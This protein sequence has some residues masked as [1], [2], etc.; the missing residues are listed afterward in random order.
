MRKLTLGLWTAG[1]L[2]L[3]TSTAHGFGFGLFRSG[4]NSTPSY[5]SSYYPSYYSSSYPYYSSY[6][7]SSYSSYYSSFY[8]S[9][10]YS[11][12]Y[13]YPTYYSS[14][15]YTPSVAYYVPTYYYAAPAVACAAAVAPVPAVPSY[16]VPTTAPASTT[17]EPPLQ[18]TP[19]RVPNVQDDA[20]K[21]GMTSFYQYTSA[22]QS[23]PEI[24]VG[25]WNMTQRDF[26]LQVGGETHLLKSDRGVT[27]NLP[28]D[29]VWQLD[30]RAA[31]A[32]SVPVN[33][34]S[35]EILIRQ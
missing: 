8:P 10:W 9:Y 32:E 19:K 20:S 28:R 16:A 29:F 23:E 6:Y 26:V 33:R 25:F 14:A 35:F 11:S 31:E 13:Y 27:L 2:M 1:L 12:S 5:R 21:P 7:P 17:N 3:W 22:R 34:S 4:S 30:Q 18:T 24:R 15:L